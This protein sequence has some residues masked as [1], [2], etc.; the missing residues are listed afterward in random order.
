MNQPC[1]VSRKANTDSISWWGS[2]RV[3]KEYGELEILFWLFLENT[4]WHKWA[5]LAYHLGYIQQLALNGLR[6]HCVCCLWIRSLATSSSGLD[7]VAQHCQFH[8]PHSPP[9]QHVGFS[10]LSLLPHSCK[11]TTIPPRTISSTQQ[12]PKQKERKK[13]YFKVLYLSSRRKNFSR[14]T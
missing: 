1:P 6:H 12:Y 4:T 13:G 2:G 5:C 11:M 10:Y 9:S 3:L 8:L 7:S 14:S